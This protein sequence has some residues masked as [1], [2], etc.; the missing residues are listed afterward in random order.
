MALIF[1]D[2]NENFH[3]VNNYNQTNRILTIQEVANILRVDR[4]TV[5][6]FAISGQLK[7]YLIGSRRL[8]KESD[9]WQF[10]ENQRDRGCVFGKER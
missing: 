6:R 8:F 5:S 3:I 2:M 9:V 1:V 7:S 10:F 4:S